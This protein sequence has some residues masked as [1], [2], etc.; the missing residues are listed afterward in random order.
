M[1]LKSDDITSYTSVFEGFGKLRISK[2][3]KNYILAPGVFLYNID[4]I[5]FYLYSP[6]IALWITYTSKSNFFPPKVCSAGVW[7]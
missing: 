1:T 4:K 2:S 7:N 3:S 5:A 6:L